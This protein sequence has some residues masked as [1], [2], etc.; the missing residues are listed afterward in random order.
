MLAWDLSGMPS[1]TFAD[2]SVNPPIVRTEFNGNRMALIWAFL[3][4]APSAA[5]AVRRLK[6]AGQRT[7]RVA[8][9]LL[10]S[11]GLFVFAFAD[12]MGV[13]PERSFG[14]DESAMPGPNDL[15]IAAHKIA[16]FL[17][18]LT[19]WILLPRRLLLPSR[20]GTDSFGANQDE[21]AA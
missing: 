16:A 18:P 15:Q 14:T 7:D 9:P 4:F 1:A 8:V 5:C 19:P 12:P 6:D 11:A 20:P 21:R 10:L 13:T 17:V 2:Y 3:I